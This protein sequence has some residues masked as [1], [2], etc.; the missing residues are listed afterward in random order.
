MSH[1]A[2]YGFLY[3]LTGEQKYADFGAQS[4]RLLLD[5][6]RDRD[7]VY[8]LID[9]EGMRVGVVLAW[10]ALGYDLCYNGW[11]AATRKDIA[12]RLLFHDA[13]RGRIS[14]RGLALEQGGG[15]HPACNHYGM[16]MW[17]SMVALALNKDPRS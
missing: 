17:L 14:V 4:M 7:S 5:G 15:K 1:A 6:Q 2:G 12:Q 11:D 13:Q 9:S 8:G 10:A 3:Q 16:A